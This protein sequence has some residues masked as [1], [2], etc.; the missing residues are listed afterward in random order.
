MTGSRINQCKSVNLSLVS[1]VTILCGSDLIIGAGISATALTDA[2]ITDYTCKPKKCDKARSEHIT[3]LIAEMVALDMQPVSI[4]EDDGFFR[5]MKYQTEP[6][7]EIPCRATV[8]SRVSKLRKSKVF[9][10]Q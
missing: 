1:L 8:S 5:Q 7:S 2:S 3:N 6:G 4:V 10:W 9:M